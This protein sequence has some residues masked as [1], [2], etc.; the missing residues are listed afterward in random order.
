MGAYVDWM[1]LH[2]T[3]E[4]FGLGLAQVVGNVRDSSVGTADQEINFWL[5]KERALEHVQQ[6]MHSPEVEF[7]RNLFLYGKRINVTS[8][9]NEKEA[10]LTKDM[11]EGMSTA[12]LCTVGLGLTGGCDWLQRRRTTC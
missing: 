12:C 4:S 11:A 5:N 1:W 7:T 6:I 9:F 2:D 8:V 3:N 10:L